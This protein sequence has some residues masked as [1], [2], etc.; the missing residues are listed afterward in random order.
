MSGSSAACGAVDFSPSGRDGL[1]AA[2]APEVAAA[3]ALVEDVDAAGAAEDV[4]GAGAAG[5]GVSGT[6]DG[7]AAAGLDV[8]AAAGASAA[9]ACVAGGAVG[10]TGAAGACT[11]ESGEAGVG[12][13]APVVAS[14]AVADRLG[15]SAWANKAAGQVAAA[16]TTEAPATASAI[17]RMRVM[18]MPTPARLGCEGIAREWP[19]P[20]NR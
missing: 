12:C 14:L 5:A 6:D 17:L 15:A 20:P 8:P 2:A 9:G 13:I 7:I 3:G 19:L 11:G 1:V 18:F 4:V 16:V 10:T